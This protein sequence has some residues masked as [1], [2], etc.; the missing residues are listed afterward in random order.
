MRYI[1]KF[2]TEENLIKFCDSEFI[3]NLDIK[4]HL[5]MVSF[6]ID[7]DAG[8][9]V[10]DVRGQTGFQ[11][12][13]EDRVFTL[14]VES[15]EKKIEILSVKKSN[16]VSANSTYIGTVGDD[17]LYASHLELLNC[18]DYSSYENLDKFNTTATGAGVNCFVIDTG[19]NKNFSYLSESNIILDDELF[20]NQLTVNNSTLHGNVDDHGHG[21][22]C[23][24]LIGGTKHGVARDS[25]IYAQKV[26]GADKS[27]SFDAILSAINNVINFKTKKS[28]VGPCIV[29]LSLGI[30]V[31]PAYP[32]IEIDTTGDNDNI[33]LD[34][35]KSLIRNGIH[36]VVAAGNG[37]PYPD[38]D[39]YPMMSKYSNGWLNLPKGDNTNSDDGQG[40]VIVVGSN[41]SGSSWDSPHDPTKMSK[42]SNYGTGNTIQ[43]TG[44]NIIVPY[45]NITSD[46][47]SQTHVR[48]DGTSFATPI[49]TGLLALHLEKNP[50]ATPAEAKT[51]LKSVARTDQLSNLLKYTVFDSKDYTF[52]WNDG[53][54]HLTITGANFSEVF[55]VNDPVQIEIENETWKS[56]NDTVNTKNDGWWEVK[57]VTDSDIS[58]TPQ[59]NA[60]YINIKLESTIINSQIKIAKLTDTHA[61]RDGVKKWQLESTENRLQWTNPDEESF[62]NQDI[63]IT[64]VDVTENLVAFNPYQP[65]TINWDNISS[66]N[67]LSLESGPF[68]ELKMLS[69]RGEDVSPTSFS[70][71][72]GS[73][74]P[75]GITLNSDGTFTKTN[76]FVESDSYNPVIIQVNNE[77]ASLQKEFQVVSSQNVV[78]DTTSDEETSNEEVNGGNDTSTE[79]ET[80]T[81]EQPTENEETSDDTS[82]EAKTFKWY[83]CGA[84][85]L[86][87][88]D[89]EY[90]VIIQEKSD[91]CLVWSKKMPVEYTPSELRT[92][93]PANLYYVETKNEIAGFDF[94]ADKKNELLS[95]CDS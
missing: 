90:D 71:A 66:I 13:S 65:Y 3:Q 89:L 78:D 9:S 1:A 46:G 59:Q 62:N 76:E 56:F 68:N 4:S 55:S 81:I 30:P 84:E 79:N 77:Y 49:V 67:L 63:H 93:E 42:F 24:L 15:T 50:N 39:M 37:F 94:N 82:V 14:D 43:A 87:I 7:T 12:I 92:I 64:N 91:R 38:D 10:E 86:Q 41:E 61:Y 25:N 73:S 70:V 6:E 32:G 40:D 58:L 18:G 72:D 16:K 48:Q 44:G 5:N 31:T 54:N 36:V 88:S 47:E 22:Y 83:N 27:G 85:A 51:W 21:T 20:E 60:D 29:N 11:K 28:D 69:E 35:I 2:D 45:W 17:D 8:Y 34:A 26:L 80:T 23:A 19:I 57:S 53:E 52:E 95:S 74:L 33:Y 75:T